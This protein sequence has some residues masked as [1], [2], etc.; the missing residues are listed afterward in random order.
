[1]NNLEL[2]NLFNFVDFENTYNDFY[3]HIGHMVGNSLLTLGIS[4]DNKIIGYSNEFLYLLKFYYELEKRQDGIYDFIVK[5][6][7]TINSLINDKLIEIDEEV[8][9]LITSFSTGTIHGY[10][11]LYYML[12]EYKKKYNGK[13]IAIFK[14]SQ[15]GILDIIYH[16]IPKSDIIELDDHQLYKI[17][18]GQF[19]KNEWHFHSRD[20]ITD[21]LKENLINE[22]DKYNEYIGKK[23][24]IIKNSR[25]QNLTS[26]GV[27]KHNDALTYANNNGYLLMEPSEFNEIDLINILYRCRDIVFTWGTAFFKNMAYLSRECEIVKCLITHDFMH[28]YYDYH[29]Y[30]KEIKYYK[31]S[32][33]LTNIIEL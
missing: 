7:R 2:N 20:S 31:V 33:D 18:K 5:Y 6:Y 23:I 22:S 3:Y 9:I 28:Q 13:K 12:I 10:A 16:V 19:I 32:K 4:A 1:M 27:I 17:K 26:V 14:Y 11:G 24:C 25:S 29:N 8:L 30:G 21:F 15:K